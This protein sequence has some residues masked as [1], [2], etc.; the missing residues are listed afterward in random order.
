MKGLR[1]IQGNIQ[2]RVLQVNRMSRSHEFHIPGR[3]VD[4][5]KYSWWMG[6]GG[7]LTCDF[8]KLDDSTT[9]V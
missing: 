7:N 4:P 1:F 2:K 5:S 6:R 8:L 9:A 3:A